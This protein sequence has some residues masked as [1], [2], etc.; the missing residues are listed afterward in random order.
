[1]VLTR[2]SIIVYLVVLFLFF[3][4]RLTN[5]VDEAEWEFHFNENL[6]EMVAGEAQDF[7]ISYRIFNRSQLKSHISFFYLKSSDDSIANFFEPFAFNDIKKNEWNR[8]NF[9]INPI[10]PGTA[11]IYFSQHDYSSTTE[12]V[13]NFTTSMKI[14]V[15]RNFSLLESKNAMIYLDTFNTVIFLILNLCFGASLD[16]RKVNSI[17]KKPAGMILAF[18]LNII[19]L[20]LVSY[21]I[22]FVAN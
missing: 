9:T 19:I 12:D 10:R 3:T 2:P 7:E 14:I 8:L 1:M 16:I 13:K 20:P 18:V 6:K 4:N 11:H 15:H 22:F 5:A 21:N 17:F